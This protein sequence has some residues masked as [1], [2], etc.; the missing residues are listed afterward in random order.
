MYS[1]VIVTLRSLEGG[2]VLTTVFWEID[3]PLSPPPKG[4]IVL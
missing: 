3:R 4:T 1:S 2:A